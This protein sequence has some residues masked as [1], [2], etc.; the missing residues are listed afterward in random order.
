MNE[1]IKIERRTEK[2]VGHYAPGTCLFSP[3]ALDSRL[4]TLDSSL[5]FFVIAKIGQHAVIFQ[6]AGVADGLFAR[7][8]VAQ[9]SPHD[10]AATGFG[11]R[12]GKA[13]GRKISRY[14][15]SRKARFQRRPPKISQRP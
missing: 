13:N 9:Q 2:T 7:G 6:C 8:N 14:D 15:K 11:Q 1:E 10:F 12:G 5:L 4:L 3:L